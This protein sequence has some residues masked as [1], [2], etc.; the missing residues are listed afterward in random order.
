M[1]AWAFLFD[2][3]GEMNMLPFLSAKYIYG[4]KYMYYVYPNMTF[5]GRYSNGIW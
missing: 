4:D 5:K 2:H 1:Q 3:A